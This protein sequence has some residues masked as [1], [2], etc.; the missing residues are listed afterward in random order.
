MQI[1]VGHTLARAGLQ[2]ASGSP[3][4]ALT[5]GRRLRAEIGR[6]GKELR[7]AFRPRAEALR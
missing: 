2:I 6:L 5:Q 1:V 3:P 4:K 7:G